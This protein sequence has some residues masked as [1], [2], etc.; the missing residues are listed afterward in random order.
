MSEV[1]TFY[2][3]YILKDRNL[4]RGDIKKFHEGQGAQKPLGP[5]TTQDFTNPGE[6][7]GLSNVMKGEGLTGRPPP[8]FRP[9]AI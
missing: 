1:V 4:S 7:R 8:S 2:V 9:Q 6:G 3:I 5:K